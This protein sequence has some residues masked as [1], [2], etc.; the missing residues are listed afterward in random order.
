MFKEKP[1]RVLSLEL[2]RE[3]FAGIC[4]FHQLAN[5][6]CNVSPDTGK[7]LRSGSII[8]HG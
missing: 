3:M 4:T 6:P 8:C 5:N 2:G 1:R 7:V